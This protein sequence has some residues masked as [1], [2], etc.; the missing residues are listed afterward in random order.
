MNKL[1]ATEQIRNLRL[2]EVAKSIDDLD[3]KL[4]T[5]GYLTPS[6][7]IFLNTLCRALQELKK[8]PRKSNSERKRA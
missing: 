3:R 7:T 5:R 6:E 1:E 8:E 2:R 4:F